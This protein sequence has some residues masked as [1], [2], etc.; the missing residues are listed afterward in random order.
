MPPRSVAPPWDI[1]SNVLDRWL[2]GAVARPV[3]LPT[4]MALTERLA[5]DP[6]L[7]S[8][9]EGLSAISERDEIFMVLRYTF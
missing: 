1:L 9:Y 6:V 2:W 4:I 3:D 8:R 7:D 5:S